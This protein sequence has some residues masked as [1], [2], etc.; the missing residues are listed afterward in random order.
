MNT[1]ISILVAID[2][3]LLGVLLAVLIDI[4]AWRRR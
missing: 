3:V 4:Y 2:L 1:L